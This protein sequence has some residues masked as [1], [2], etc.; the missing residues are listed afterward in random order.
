MN[1]FKIKGVVKDYAWGNHDFI[2][3]LIGGYTDKPQAELWMG[4]HPAGDAMLLDGEKLSDYI[5]LHP[6]I[7]GQKRMDEYGKLPLLF[8][9]L[10]IDK[11]LSLQCHPNLQQAREGWE[12]EREKREKGEPCNYQDDNEKAEII[13]ALS[14]MTAMC[15][16][17]PFDEIT[18]NLSSIIPVSYEKHLAKLR[19]AKALF[20]GIY[21]LSD[22]EKKELLVEAYNSIGKSKKD[23]KA[24]EFLTEKGIFE[25]CW[26]EYP[27]D[28]GALF[29]YILN[30]IHLEIGEGL[31]LKPDTLHAYVLGNGVE[32][33]SA[34]DNVLR[35]GLTKK[36]IDLDELERIMDFTSGKIDK[37]EIVK[38]S[39]GRDVYK[40]PAKA[41]SLVGLSS[42]EYKIQDCKCALMIVIDGEAKAIDDDEELSL[43]KGEIA[44]IGKSIKHYTLEVHGQVFM[45]EV[46]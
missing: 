42:G 19:D 37:V 44:L 40:T 16:F 13:V 12:K 46:P 26:I 34:S 21:H 5:N 8:K 14:P 38:D 32:L 30:V 43:K 23:A 6:E 2:P 36:R 4:T 31:F 22:E 27:N 28:I 20:L 9:I 18:S 11:P 3:S 24:G 29:P 33:M 1:M 10:A 25:K 35:G 15:G 17:R 7:I 41:F 39:F 45:A